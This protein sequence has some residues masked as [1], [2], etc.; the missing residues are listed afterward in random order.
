[1]LGMLGKKQWPLYA[2]LG[3]AVFMAGR[4]KAC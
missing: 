4:R 2:F 3:L 1:M